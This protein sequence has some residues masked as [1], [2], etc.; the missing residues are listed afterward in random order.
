MDYISNYLDLVLKGNS[1]LLE[2]EKKRLTC[3]TYSEISIQLT[4]LRS[5]QLKIKTKDK[6]TFKINNQI[7]DKSNFAKRNTYLGLLNI[8]K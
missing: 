7:N 2:R 4:V 5:Q 3:P 1:V 8:E 6:H